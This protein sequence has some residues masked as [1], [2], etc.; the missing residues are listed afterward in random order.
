MQ[1]LMF[2]AMIRASLLFIVNRLIG[3]VNSQ[4]QFYFTIAFIIYM[5]LETVV[6]LINALTRYEFPSPGE[7]LSEQPSKLIEKD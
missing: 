1:A 5:V 3:T 7:L 2:A 6:I 4:A